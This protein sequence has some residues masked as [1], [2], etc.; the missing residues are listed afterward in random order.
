MW[1]VPQIPCP[2]FIVEVET[3]R[4]AKLLL[5]VLAQYDLHQYRT[6]IKPDYTNIGGVQEEING[7]WWDVD[8]DDPV[9]ENLE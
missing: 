3:P 7:D 5:D 6:K 4:E 1:W 9:W 8:T 2:Q